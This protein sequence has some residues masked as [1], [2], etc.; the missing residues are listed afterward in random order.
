M[1]A[2]L[3]DA[4]DAFA[5]SLATVVAFLPRLLASL[6]IIAVGWVVAS[7]LGRAVTAMLRAI[8]LN[9]LAQRSGLSEFIRNMGFRATTADVIGIVTRWFVRLIALVVAFDALGLPAVS[10]V[11]NELP[12]WLPNLV[13]ALVVLMVWGLAAGALSR[14]VKATATEAGFSNPDTLAA[15]ARIAA[16]SFAVVVAINQLGIATVLINTLM[17]GLVGALAIAAGLAFGLGGRDRAALALEKWVG[18]GGGAPPPLP[19]GGTASR[20]WVDRSG[21]DRRRSSTSG[22]RD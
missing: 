17:I 2:P 3:Q 21:M 22:R 15:I 11:L 8:R 14:L 4:G 1:V 5:A 16:W 20:V 7:L 18:S 12:L 9:E 13:V 10:S 19:V 6:L